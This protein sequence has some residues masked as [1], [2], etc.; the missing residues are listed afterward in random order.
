MHGS[1]MDMVLF[2]KRQSCE[3]VVIAAF[4]E[5]TPA[6]VD[7]ADWC[8]EDSDVPCA[9]VVLAAPHQFG[10]AEDPAIQSLAGHVVQEGRHVVEVCHGTFDGGKHAAVF[11]RTAAGLRPID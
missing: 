10:G 4:M 2:L 9:H 7:R 3:A 8:R 11:V 1:S 6:I 5:V